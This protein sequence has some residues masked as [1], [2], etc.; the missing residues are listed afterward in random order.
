MADNQLRAAAAEAGTK[1]V[2]AAVYES[3]QLTAIVIDFIVNPKNS[4]FARCK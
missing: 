4:M 1:E 2:N 3:G